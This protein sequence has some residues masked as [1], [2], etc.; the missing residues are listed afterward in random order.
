MHISELWEERAF[1]AMVFLNAME[2]S[3]ICLLKKKR[4]V[5]PALKA[6]DGL[7]CGKNGFR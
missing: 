4:K 1:F 3:Y 7:I 2:T 6:F 5:D